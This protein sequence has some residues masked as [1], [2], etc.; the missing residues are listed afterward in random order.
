M[1]P[2]SASTMVDGADEV[3]AV[4]G[5]FNAHTMAAALEMYTR[6]PRP[7]DA[8]PED[9]WNEVLRCIGSIHVLM[10]ADLGMSLPE[11]FMAAMRAHRDGQQ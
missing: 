11:T 10:T 8:T 1:A 3:T 9:N 7:A 5:V 6:A 4:V 2:K